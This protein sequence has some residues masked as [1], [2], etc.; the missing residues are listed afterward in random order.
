MPARRRQVAHSRAF[1]VARSAL[2][3][4]SRKATR[5][6][7]VIERMKALAAQY[8]A[9]A[10][11]AF[12]SF[13]DGTDTR[14]AQGELTG[15]GGQRVCKCRASG[16]GNAWLRAVRGHKHRRGRTRCGPT[17]SCS[18]A[19]PTVAAQMPDGDRRVHQGRVGDRRRRP[20][21]LAARDRGALRPGQRARRAGSPT[22]RQWS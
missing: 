4:R 19:A 13:L 8:R 11:G 12:A 7:P 14:W 16:Q 10:I 17:T 20:H 1:S 21:L 2:D 15:C 6:A 18:T 5:D 3:Y 22:Q 9:L